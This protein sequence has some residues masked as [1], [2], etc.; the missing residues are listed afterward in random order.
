M[1]QCLPYGSYTGN[2][3]GSPVTLTAPLAGRLALARVLR[4]EW[5]TAG[6][7]LTIRIFKNVGGSFVL[8]SSGEVAS[9]PTTVK[10]VA[11]NNPGLPYIGLEGDGEYRVDVETSAA[12][13][14]TTEVV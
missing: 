7:T 6:K 9:G 2:Q 14:Y 10:G 1:K 4:D 12:L 13:G 8:D 5:N 3:Q 11:Q